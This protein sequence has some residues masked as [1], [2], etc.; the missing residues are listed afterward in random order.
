MAECQFMNRTN[1]LSVP[2][3]SLPGSGNTWTRGL[4]EK[5]T[6]ICTGMCIGTSS[7]FFELFTLYMY[8]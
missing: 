8:V 7:F 6:G 1:R 5:A 4:L 3:V 2:L